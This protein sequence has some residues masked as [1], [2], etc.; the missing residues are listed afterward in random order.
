[1]LL[2][3]GAIATAQDITL[4]D[5]SG[6]TEGRDESNLEL[7]TGFTTGSHPTGYTISGVDV[8]LGDPTGESTAVALYQQSSGG[9][10]GALVATLTNPTL[11]TGLNRFTAP[12]GTTLEANTSYFLVVNDGRRSTSTTNVDVELTTADSQT[13]ATGWSIANMSLL[14]NDSSSTWVATTFANEAIRFKILGSLNPPEIS[15]AQPSGEGSRTLLDGR[16]L[17]EE[18]E[19]GA[20][21]TVTATSAPSTALTVCLN[22]AET[23]ANRVD[24]SDE[25]AKTVTIPATMRSATYRV[26]W[27]AADTDERDSVLAI[28]VV[29]PSDSSCS[30]TGYTVSASEG[31]ETITIMDQDPTPVTLAGVAGDIN[32]GETKTFTVSLGRGLVDSEVLPIRLDFDGT[33]TRGTDYTVSCPLSLPTGV[34]CNNLNTASTPTITFTGPSTGMTATSVTLTLSATADSMSESGGE[35]VMIDLATLTANSGTGLGGGAEGTD[36]LADFTIR[37]VP[38][39]AL[40]VTNSGAITEGGTALT[41]T[42]TRSEAN[43]SGSAL[44]IPIQV[45]SAATTAEAA[46]YTLATAISIPD[47][48]TSGTTSFTVADDSVDE[49][50]E[51]VVVELGNLPQGNAEGSPSEV[52]ITITDNDPTI[53][54]LARN[55]TGGISE[56]DTVQFTVTLGRALVAD[57]II[58]VPLSISGTGVTLPDWSL[59]LAS[60]GSLN[61]GVTLTGATTA[62]PQVTFTG[63]AETATLVLTALRDPIPENDETITVALGPNGSGTNGFDRSGLSTNVDGGADPASA[64]ADNRFNVVVSNVVSSLTISET[65]DMAVEGSTTE[66]AT[67]TVVLDI[68]PSNTVTVTV[69]APTALTLDGPDSAT[70]FNQSEILTFSTT[71]WNIAQTVTVR[72]VEDSTDSPRGRI[73]EVTY[74]VSSSDAGYNGRGGRAAMITVIDNDPTLVTLARNGTGGISEGDTVQFTVTLGRALV[75]GEIIDVPLSISGT[76]VTTDDWSLAL[77]SGGSLNTG[78]TLT[79]A[80]TATPQVTFSGAAAETA[81]LVLTAQTDIVTENDETI[82]VALGP[83][84]SG[85]NGFDRSGLSTNVGGGADPA[86]DNTFDVVVSN[87]VPPTDPTVALSV[88]NSGAIT[89]GGTALTITATRSEANDSGSALSIPIQVQSVGTTADAADYTLVTAISIPDTVTSGTASFTVAD[90]SVDEPDETVVV[91]LGTL[92]VGTAEGSPSEVMIT[93]TDNDPTMVTL[94]RSGTGGISEG[95]TVQFTVMLGR[96]L[97]AGEI[98]DVPLSISGTGVT[99]D[100]W[101]LALA[102]GGSLNTGVTLTGATTAMP[103]VRFVGSA[104]ET[105]T[106]VLTAQTDIDT[107]NDETITVALGPNGSGTNGFDRSGLS[108][109]VGGGAD[110]ASD[111]TFDVVVSNVVPPTDPTV[112]LSVTNSGAITEGGTA[113]TITATRSEANDSGSALSIPIQVRSAGTTAEAADYTLAAAISISNGATSGMT[114]FTAS[115]DD[116]TDEPSETVVIELG[117]LPAGTVAG[118]PSEV[119]ITITNISSPPSRP[120][121]PPSQPSVPVITLTG[122]EAATEGDVVTFMLTASPAPSAEITV[123]MT[124]EEQGQFAR[125]GE[126]G[127]RT[128]TIGTTGQAT[129]RVATQDDAVY[130]LDGAIALALMTGADYNLVGDAAAEIVVQDNDGPYVTITSGDPVIEGQVSVFTLTADANVR[131]LA[132][133]TIQLTVSDAFGADFLAVADEGRRTV[134]LNMDQ[135][136]VRVRVPTQADDIVESDGLITVELRAGS[137]YRVGSPGSASVRVRDIDLLSPKHRMATDAGLVRFGRTVGETAVSSVRERLLAPGSLGFQIYLAGEALPE[138]RGS[139]SD[140]PVDIVQRDFEKVGTVDTGTVLASRAIVTNLTGNRR[141]ADGSRD[142]SRSVSREEFIGG[143]GFAATGVTEEGRVLGVWGRG[144]LSEFS[145]NDDGTR[146]DGEVTTLSIGTDWGMTVTEGSTDSQMLGLMVSRSVGE[147]S[148]QGAAASGRMETN[149]T[150]VV[151]WGGHRQANGLLVW[152]TLGVGQGQMTMMPADAARMTVDIDWHMVAGGMEG[153]LGTLPTAL[154]LSSDARLTWSADALWTW[155]M[156]DEVV[157]LTTLGGETSRV[158]FGMESTWDDSEVW[159][160]RLTPRLEVGLRYDDGDAEIGGGLEVGGGLSWSDPSGGISFN[161]EGRVLARHEDQDFGNWGVSATLAYDVRP[162]TKRGF[163]ARLSHNMGGASSGGVSALLTPETLPDAGDESAANS[164]WSLE[165]AYGLSRGAGMVGESYTRLSGSPTLEV[166]RLG[167]RIEPDTE[168]AANAHVDVWIEPGTRESTQEALG[169]NLEWRW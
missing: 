40:S 87:V 16:R 142:E 169:V 32:E 107:E 98:I 110:P 73:E 145:G 105:A 50:D 122:G 108:T 17:Y 70:T 144:T 166:A 117:A 151:P 44:S 35:T 163:S 93:I 69:D 15:I 8:Q 62:T 111:N 90:D 136:T 9:T 37:D 3:W 78:V 94:V 135:T 2:S 167:Y 34:T 29:P 104:A 75:A 46:D 12:V 30:Q 33:A 67:F 72:A 112:A 134:I 125:L 58:D 131:L 11:S 48:A 168:H 96:A 10:P 41:I 109:N 38:T 160:G 18:L 26:P 147:I 89:E 115:T 31:S 161:L 74:L 71:T 118:T 52:M 138:I 100:D 164:A 1:M 158:R 60:G 42:A 86:S 141:M 22:I 85:T 6:L 102:S 162:E 76:E 65:D 14:R 165:S 84:G 149:L 91:E 5:N 121:P 103:Q 132:P 156:S 51:T 153:A 126:I 92:P 63:A 146:L 45:R 137:G 39:V 128:V 143:T 101:S 120:V 95:D 119:T 124:I 28:T 64:A 43:D 80:T 54:T 24:T 4:V 150:A 77:A 53:V 152:G 130:E 157:G 155:T 106:L 61:T 59:A 23:L 129:V 133:L 159:G 66:A 116:I 55:G 13:G 57:E 99:T 139:A 81:T 113:L 82:T 47:T 83:N 7:A 27:T 49:L 88:T 148:Y 127:A 97:V 68:E 114:T 36:N 154:F 25:G 56:G 20:T 140:S 79:G 19:G 123:A 21:F